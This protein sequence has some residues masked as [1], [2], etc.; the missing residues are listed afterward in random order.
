MNVDAIQSYIQSR[1]REL[2][3]ESPFQT[4][5]RLLDQRGCLAC[6]ERDGNRGIME[7]AKQVAQ[8]IPTLAGKSEGMIPPAL[9]AVGDKLLDKALAEAVSGEQ[10]KRR[11]SWLNV[12]M[13]R[14]QHSADDK[15]ALL[16][17]F[18]GHDRI[19]DDAPQSNIALATHGNSEDRSE[20][21]VAGHTL[22]GPR[23]F[24]CIACHE[25]G[26]YVPRNVALGTHGSDLLMLGE[27][28]RKSFFVRWTRAPLRI[29]PGM[30]MPS[31]T[32]P[33]PGLLD[34]QVNRQLDAIWRAVNDPRFTPPTNPS[35]VEQF[36]VV[37]PGEPA[38]IVRDVFKQHAPAAKEGEKL[39]DEFIP[40][41]FAVGL[42]NGH[43]VLLDLDTGAVR[44]W[45]FGDFAR[46]ETMGKSWYWSL[47]GVPVV[48]GFEA[49]S[50]LVLTPS[51]NSTEGKASEFHPVSHRLLRYIT[52]ENG[53]EFE[54]ELTFDKPITATVHLRQQI[55]A[56]AGHDGT[57]TGS[58]RSIWPTGVPKDMSLWLKVAP[59]LEPVGK[60]QARSRRSSVNQETLNLGA[61]GG[62]IRAIK[63]PTAGGKTSRPDL[64]IAFTADLE[65]TNLDLKPLERLVTTADPIDCLPGFTGMRL[66]VDAS[67]MPTAL[68]W[69][70]NGHLVFTSLKGHVY[71]AEDSNADGIEDRLTVI[72]EGLA[73]PFGVISD[74]DDLI[75]AH[76][77]EVLRLIDAGTGQQPIRRDVVASG[78][79]YTD[80]YHD[81]TCGIVRDADGLL[82]VGL[83]SDYG[84]P[85]R[86]AS[87]QKWRG[88]ILRI[89]PRGSVDSPGRVEPVAFDLRYPTGLA[90]DATGRIF[91]SDQQ[92]VQNTFNEINLLVR[93]KHYGVPSLENREA[94]EP[95]EWPAVQIPH[96]WTRSVNGLAFLPNDER[97]GPFAGHGI[98]CEYNE[99]LLIRF[100]TQT[101]DGVTQGACYYFS[102]PDAADEKRFLGPM[103]AAISPAGEL[104]VGSIHDSGWLGG[105]NTG[106]IVRLT[107]TGMW[108]NGIREL[109]ATPDGFELEFVHPIEPDKA[110]RAA[111]YTISG[112]T[113]E[114]AGSYA[115][116]D[117]GRYSPSI[118]Q[119]EISGDRRQVRL[120]L[121]DLRPNYVYEV[122]CDAIGT[123][124][125][126]ELFPA[127]GHYTMKRVPKN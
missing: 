55:T 61:D 97:F 95:G 93:G 30:E 114:W 119:V 111:A 11:L 83:G 24:S 104:L 5:Q 102:R 32:K 17:Y 109:R 8:D 34:G 71:R 94:N 33:V 58:V 48:G 89:E 80:N 79:G 3:A 106:E 113:R 35:V 64:S 27:R 51:G 125:Q 59:F 90:M 16:A 118:T 23:G 56:T 52:I 108:P 29:V 84:D 1:P 38:R 67:I 77:P 105:R 76:K 78:W 19:P 73:A 117:S 88:S 121:D 86:P 122:T 36:F 9:T 14:F 123:G 40:R 70:S 25:A 26:S 39:R 50:D 37:E 31:Y 69:D 101:V 45:T 96:P 82:Y 100:T 110:A 81:W 13:P 75:V 12:R 47:E 49:K 21:L 120:G 65:R 72:E 124:D 6:H 115:S 44:E 42:P 74:G 116:P 91:I 28:M 99:R 63:S 7:I 46:Q 4:G 92:G 68:N 20:I 41:A 127:T 103:C 53:V 18:I 98:G 85:K 43:N 62:M 126:S 57:Q 112:Y 87:G 66:P 2:S 107:P 60:P 54:C 10:P 22:V 15:A